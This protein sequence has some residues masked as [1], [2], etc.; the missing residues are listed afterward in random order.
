MQTHQLPGPAAR[1]SLLVSSQCQTACGEPQEPPRRVGQGRNL[2]YRY[3]R[4]VIQAPRPHLRRP[5]RGT[6]P[7]HPSRSAWNRPAWVARFLVESFRDVKHQNPTS[8]RNARRPDV[9]R[10]P[11][12]LRGVT[13]SRAPSTP[14]PFSPADPTPLSP[15][16]TPRADRRDPAAHPRP[17]DSASP[18]TRAA[19]VSP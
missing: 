7:I 8:F 14:R 16:A 4:G 15:R 13:A 2:N 17:R 11:D 19:V 12:H 9:A 6:S 5:H 10:L 3:F 18:E 1:V